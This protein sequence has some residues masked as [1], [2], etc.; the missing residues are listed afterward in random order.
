M[1]KSIL[2][3][4]ADF[5]PNKHRT[6]IKGQQIPCRS[7]T[8]SFLKLTLFLAEHSGLWC[9]VLA[10]YQ[11]DILFSPYLERPK[12]L[13]PALINS[14]IRQKHKKF[15]VFMYP[16]YHSKVQIFLWDWGWRDNN[17]CVTEYLCTCMSKENKVH[18]EL[19]LDN[20]PVVKAV[21]YSMCVW[22]W[23]AGHTHTHT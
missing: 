11:L 12:I 10:S 3:N 23:D 5:T 21:P 8:Y 2:Q 6:C 16:L 7:N 1:C 9:L 4:S 13:L 20:N 18:C 19:E 15:L 17:N 22:M 14:Y